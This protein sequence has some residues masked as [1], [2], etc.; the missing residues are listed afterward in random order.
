MVVTALCISIKNHKN[1]T[2]PQ[3]ITSRQQVWKMQVDKYRGKGEGDNL[4]I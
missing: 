1:L 3:I 4:N 2:S